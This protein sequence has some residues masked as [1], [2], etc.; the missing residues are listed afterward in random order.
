MT[1]AFYAV[2]LIGNAMEEMVAVS[3]FRAV[4]GR[5]ARSPMAL[6]LAC[7]LFAV[8]RLV[9]AILLNQRELMMLMMVIC[10]A[11]I[12]FS[13][14]MAWMKRLVFIVMFAV[15][16]IITEMLVGLL[17]ASAT[18]IPVAEGREMILYYAAGV[19]ISKMLMFSLLKVGQFLIPSFGE[20]IPGYLLLPLLVLPAATFAVTCVLAEYSYTDGLSSRIYVA[21]GALVL[22]AVSNAALFFLFE[23]QQRGER[24]KTRARLLHQQMADQVSYYQ[25]LAERQ[26][27]SNKTIHDLKNQM[28]ALAEAIKNEPDQAQDRMKEIADR[29]FAASPMTVTGNEAL[30][31]LIFAKRQQMETE[32]IRYVQSVYVS[33]DS[34][35]DSLDMCVL[36]GNLLDNAI[37]ACRKVEPEKRRITLKMTQQGSCMS[38]SVINTIAAKISI[39]NNTVRT[40]K[41]QPALHGFGLSSIREIAEKYSGN[42]T[43]RSSDTEFTACILLQEE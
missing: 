36:L 4:S 43:F 19:L 24:E 41:D 8:I 11:A 28:F 38:I 23:Y 9:P 29:I 7:V 5:R 20:K 40:T 10:I 37:E 35:F 32:Q 34:R 2:D 30:D 27:V 22:L 13:Y 17:L 12:S 6:F 21:A 15:S 3:L 33:P 26:K 18:G 14:E 39:V 25:A 42:F 1:W 31:A 16:V